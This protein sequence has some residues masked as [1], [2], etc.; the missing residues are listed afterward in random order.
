MTDIFIFNSFKTLIAVGGVVFFL[1]VVLRLTTPYSN[2]VL[3]LLH[4]WSKNKTVQIILFIVII[5]WFVAKMVYS[6]LL[7]SKGLGVLDILFHF[8]LDL[9]ISFLIWS[10]LI[11]FMRFA[12]VYLVDEENPNK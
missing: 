4:L 9:I 8:S 10:I 6:S 5:L 11:A 7:Y 12:Y 3:K 1:L 2:G